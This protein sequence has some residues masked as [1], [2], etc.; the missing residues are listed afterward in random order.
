MLLISCSEQASEE[1]DN[2]FQQGDY[3]QAVRLY[4]DYLEINPGDIKTLYNRGRAY[5][6]MELYELAFK[7]FVAV[8][9]ED[10]ENLQ[11]N[12]SVGSYYY[13]KQDYDE[14]LHFFNQAIKS[15]NNPAINLSLRFS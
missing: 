13:N 12:L 4:S 11:A 8:L 5:E 3:E 6:E 9:E 7:D 1:G 2:F 15:R 14:A 10:G